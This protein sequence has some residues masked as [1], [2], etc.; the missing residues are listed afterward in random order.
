[1][2]KTVRKAL[3]VAEV[4]EITGIESTTVLAFIQRE[5][6]RPVTRDE[7]DHE[8]IAR[9]HLITELRGNLGANDEAIPIILH[10]LD[11][12]YHL[13]HQLEKIEGS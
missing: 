7:I 2:S 13:R 1:M 8:D 3:S 10:L 11:Q 12:L 4:S 9:I 6:I 5:W